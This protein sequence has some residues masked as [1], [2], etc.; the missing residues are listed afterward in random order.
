MLILLVG[1][2]I[3]ED[4]VKL[5]IR[6]GGNDAVHE[7]EE[8]DATAPIRMR[9]DD[10]SRGDLE[11]CK[12]GRRAMPLVVVALAGQGAPVRQLQ[13]AL[14]SLQR[15]D[16]RLFVDAKDNGLRGRIDIETD[17][18]GGFGRKLGIV[19]L[20]PGLAGRKVDL[21]ARRNRQTY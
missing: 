17:N 19:A 16:R 14:R 4:D 8:L 2:E 3:I 5:A 9:G 20:A 10:L 13:I 1:V 11:C 18:V 15:L 12:Q 6:K 7:A 21:V